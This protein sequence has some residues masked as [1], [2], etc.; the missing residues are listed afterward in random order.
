MKKSLLFLV[1]E[2]TL[3]ITGVFACEKLGATKEGFFIV[4][5]VIGSSLTVVCAL[6]DI[7]NLIKIREKEDNGL[8]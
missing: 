4:G 7:S 3:A 6:L 8:H 5:W 2:I 1:I